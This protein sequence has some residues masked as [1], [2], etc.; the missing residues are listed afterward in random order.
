ML[1][2]SWLFEVQIQTT[3]GSE[4]PVQH[5][6][7][8]PPDRHHIVRAPAPGLWQRGEWWMLLAAQSMALGT[9]MPTAG[10]L[11]RDGGGEVAWGG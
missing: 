11:K 9:V 7:I 6:A 10:G 3:P 2:P 1:A 8:W 4:W 5:Q